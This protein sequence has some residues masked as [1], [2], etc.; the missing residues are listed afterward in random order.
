MRVALKFAYDGSKFH[1]YARQPSL[2][3]VEGH[4][5]KAFVKHGF[6][7]DIKESVLRSASRTDKSVSAFGNVIAFNTNASKTNIIKCLYD[8]F[9]D[10]VVFGANDVKFDFNPR[11]AK[12]RKY[13]YHLDITGLDFEKIITCSYVFTGEHNFSNF[14]RIE[15]L[16]D[17]VRTIDNIVFSKTSNYLLIDFFAQTFLWNQ[18]RRIISSLIKIGNGKIQKDNIVNALNNPDKKVDFGVASAEPLILEDIFYDF[19]FNLN[20]ESLIKLE[21]LKKTILNK[22]IF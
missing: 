11:Y 7:K 5:I 17:P 19:D 2:R 21:E 4:L 20:K 10:I 6:I 14:A 12:Y 18:I 22:I 3:T 1:G 15:S 13:R 9:E 16:K 8:E